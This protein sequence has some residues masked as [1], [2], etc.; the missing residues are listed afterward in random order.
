ME[1]IPLTPRQRELLGLPPSSQPATPGSTY[2][3][4]PRYTRSTPRSTSSRAALAGSSPFRRSLSGSPMAA[5]PLTGGGIGAGSP[6]A[7]S[8]GSGSPY[9]RKAT[10]KRYSLGDSVFGTPGVIL[11]ES[12][13]SLPGSPSPTGPQRGVSVSLNNKWLYQKQ[14][15]R[16][17]PSSLLF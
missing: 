4:P 16:G 10:R 12:S 15:E 13:T 9:V 17:S 3:T 6:F 5:S 8:P 2:I 7:S 14:K 11:D 1:D